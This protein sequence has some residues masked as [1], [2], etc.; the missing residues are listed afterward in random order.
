[1]QYYP[2]LLLS[3]LSSGVLG[4]VQLSSP[5]PFRGRS[6]PHTKNVDF[7]NN[8]PVAAGAFPCKGY[9]VAAMADPTGEGT[10]TATWKTGEQASFTFGEGAPHGGGSCQASLSYDSGKTWTVIHSFMG[11]CPLAPV[12]FTVPA[13]AP[14]KNNVLG[15]WSWVN[16]IGNREFYQ[17]CFALNVEQG[18]GGAAPKIP[19][20]QRP[21]IFV[22]NIGTNG[23]KTVE[24]FDPIYPNPGPDVTGAGTPGGLTGD[25][26]A[27]ASPPPPA[28]N[29]PAPAPAPG[30]EPVPG[31]S[32][33][34]VSSIPSSSFATATGAPPPSTLVTATTPAGSASPVAPGSS[35]AVGSAPGAVPTGGISTDGSCGGSE[36]KLCAAPN[37]CSSS[38]YCGSSSD[39]C[40]VGCQPAFG[41]C[42]S[43]NGTVKRRGLTR[44]NRRN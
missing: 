22:A 3:I 43:S 16:H 2:I 35:S 39:H 23:C 44:H 17:N 27:A 31:S 29:Q 10:P 33:A 8:A 30:S 41:T 28:G 38:S 13:D 24:G 37:C 12:S 32:L 5:A 40:G 19:F 11:G 42:S 4:H 26:G 21:P 9:H 25:C 1:M 18:S 20:S 36:G 15:S 14:V 6:N 34:P 7:D